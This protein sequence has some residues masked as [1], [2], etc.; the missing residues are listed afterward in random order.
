MTA[1]EHAA[2]ASKLL[3]GVEL[4]SEK[5]AGMTPDEHLQ[6]VVTGGIS[7]YNKDLEWTTA[8]AQAHA[9]TSLALGAL[10]PPA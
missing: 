9:L 4:A 6:M 2:Y 1:R 5:L 3:E 7:R 10:E 8:L